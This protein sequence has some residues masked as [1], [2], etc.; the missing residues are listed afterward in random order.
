MA[1]Q[2]AVSDDFK[3]W[4]YRDDRKREVDF[5]VEDI[6]GALLG[7][8]VKAGSSVGANDFAHL[9]W[10][11]ANVAKDRPYKGIVLYA[12]CDTLRFG[13]GFHAVPLAML[14]GTAIDRKPSIA[15][16]C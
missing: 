13:E 15:V 5:L 1:A 10:F 16:P 11:D 3:I 4:H 7:I 2:A 9:K 8:E 12:G 14:Y 6:D